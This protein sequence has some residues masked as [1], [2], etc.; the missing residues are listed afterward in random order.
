MYDAIRV[1]AKALDEMA[2]IEGLSV[3][4]VNCQQRNIFMSGEK[5]LQYIRKV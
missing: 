1:L 3:N 4:P 2:S 5:I